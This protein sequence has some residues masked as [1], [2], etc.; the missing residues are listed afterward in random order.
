MANANVES[1]VAEYKAKLPA[2]KLH[3]LAG[4]AAESIFGKDLAKISTILPDLISSV[5]GKIF[6]LKSAWSRLDAT[7]KENL[8]DSLAQE[9]VFVKNFSSLDLAKWDVENQMI[10]NDIIPLAD[11]GKFFTNNSWAQ[12]HV[13]MQIDDYNSKL[14]LANKII[15]T[16][17]TVVDSY[18]NSKI[19]LTATQAIYKLKKKSSITADEQAAIKQYLESKNAI[20]TSKS[21]KKG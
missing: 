7:N 13:Q 3:N 5:L 18:E 15:E 8:I 2:T 9:A 11:R 19:Q 16:T 1:I 4:G 6:K 12:N 20:A 14:A 21:L 17:R 10:L